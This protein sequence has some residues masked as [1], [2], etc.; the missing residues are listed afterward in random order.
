METIQKNINSLRKKVNNHNYRYYVLDDPLISDSEY[1]DLLRHLNTLEKENPKLITPDSPT[2]RVG[3]EPLSKF[4]TLTHTIPMLSLANA[5]NK[6]EIISFDERVKKGLETDEHIEYMGEPKLDGLGVEVVYKNGLFSHGSTRGDGV[7]GEDITLN[8]RTIRSLPLKLREEDIP[9]PN[10]LEVRGEVFIAKDDFSELNC[11]REEKEEPLFANPRNAAAGSLRQLDPSVTSQRPLS[12]FFYQLGMAEGILFESQNE[13]IECAKKWGLPINPH[14]KQLYGIN[15]SVMYYE[16]ME[17][18]RNNLPY[19]I[20]GT[21]LK[22]N[23]FRHQDILGTRSRSPRWAIAGK[24]K[25]QQATSVILDIDVQVGRTGAVT[26]VA[27]L[28]PVEVGGV[29]VSNATL[30]NQDEIKKKDIRI[31]DMVFLERAGDV[32]PKVVKVVLEKRPPESMAFVFP[33]KCPV[34]SQS[35]FKPEDEAVYRCQNVSCLAQVKGRIQHFTSKNALDIEGFGQKLVDQFVDE[36]LLKSVDGIYSLKQEDLVKL[37]GMGE[38]SVDNLLEELE[39]SKN[40]TFSRFLFGLGIRNVGEHLSRVF[41]KEFQGN[42]EK[43]MKADVENLA[44]IHE[45]GPIVAEC[46]VRFWENPENCSMVN[47]C[48]FAGVT[49]NKDIETLNNLHFDGNIFVFTGALEQFSRSKAKEMVEK[50]GGRASESVSKNTDYVI[51]GPGAGYKKR[52]AE[53]LGIDILTEEEFIKL[54]KI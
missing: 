11:V 30:H 20:D 7:T 49:P 40:T 46:V 8:L 33:K 9:V 48:F 29:T 43:F 28:K 24:F 31:G 32:I 14:V 22:V 45:V 39:K 53:E 27:R 16:E 52:K 18:M 19:E 44:A 54:M 47:A 5:K 15:K 6:E 23:S 12:I 36:G 4:K 51:V 1:D 38:K 26:P 50:F 25:A 35:L 2:Q 41:S 13:F 3:A 10:L 37:E 42:F 17:L 21:V 34:C